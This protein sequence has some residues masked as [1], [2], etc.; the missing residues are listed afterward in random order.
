MQQINI[1]KPE[2]KKLPRCVCDWNPNFLLNKQ[3]HRE[4]IYIRQASICDTSTTTWFWNKG[5]LSE[6]STSV[7]CK[8]TVPD[9]RNNHTRKNLPNSKV[10]NVKSLLQLSHGQWYSLC[11]N[12]KIP[13]EPCQESFAYMHKIQSH[14]KVKLL[15]DDSHNSWNQP[16]SSHILDWLASWNILLAF[17]I[18]GFYHFLW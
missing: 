16:Y 9:F 11:S 14:M 15:K 18:L 8:T 2:F 6:N 4:V 12:P 5:T 7:L 17:R 10:S 1:S 3:P 13:S